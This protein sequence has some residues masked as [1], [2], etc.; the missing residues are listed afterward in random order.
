MR[1]LHTSDWHIGRTFHGYST[2]DALRGV[3]GAL[4]GEVRRRDVDVVVVAGDVFDTG[5]PAAS[6]YTVLT[7]ALREIGATGAR[8][9]LTSGNHDNAARLGFTAPLL[10]DGIH[11]ITDPR[12]VGAPVTIDDAH[13]PVH[14]YG[15]P[16]L[17]PAIVRSV[18]PGAELRTQEHAIRHAMGLVNADR[19]ERGGRSV[20][21]SHC[22]AG[23]V[24]PTA[25]VERE[26]RQGTL[27]VVP[28]ADFGGPDYVA[29][30]HIHGRSRLAE[31]VR[32][33]GAPLHYSF[34]EGGKPRGAWIVD[35]GADGVEGVEWMDLPVP[36]RLTTLRGPLDDLL[37]DER[38]APHEGDWVCAVLT[39]PNPPLEPMRKLKAR[40]PHC[41]TV[42]I[43]PE[44]GADADRR[45]FRERVESARSDGELVDD[46]LAHV[47]GGRRATDA[48][49]EI[50]G[51]V[52]STREGAEARA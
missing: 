22:F 42:R 40:F 44:G 24:E 20:V 30:G 17:E 7:D 21:V 29:L 10:R 8:I 2:L 26:I 3:L 47:R 16:Y 37:T 48:E 49:R 43:A 50:I 14:F 32:Y 51:D 27:D 39:D 52:V 25:G 31:N 6:C 35:I 19:A 33:S 1:I 13:G 9:V 4:V 38:L 46:F 28:L 34:G 11:V 5:T 36:R 45:T 15:I 12:A 23:D 18:W 41:A